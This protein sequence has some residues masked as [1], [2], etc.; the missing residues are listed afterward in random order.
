MLGRVGEQ[1]PGE[2]LFRYRATP[3]PGG[4]SPAEILMGRRLRTRLKLSAEARAA[5]GLAGRQ[6]PT[7]RR[8]LAAEL[9]P[10]SKVAAGTGHCIAFKSPPRQPDPAAIF[11]L[12]G[13]GVGSATPHGQPLLF[14]LMVALSRDKL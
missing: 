2:A 1:R 6:V 9:R 3:L 11:Q 14:P 10:R 4:L 8:R 13:G 12:R 7:R 5:H